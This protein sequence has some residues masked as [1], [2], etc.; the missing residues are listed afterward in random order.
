M[1]RRTGNSYPQTNPPNG[2]KDDEDDTPPQKSLQRRTIFQPP[3]AKDSNFSGVTN[4]KASMPDWIQNA[5]EVRTIFFLVS[6]LIIVSGKPSL[7]NDG[8][9]DTLLVSFFRFHDSHARF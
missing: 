7:C 1:N 9:Q 8:E 5:L 6:R 3:R 2:H 4:E